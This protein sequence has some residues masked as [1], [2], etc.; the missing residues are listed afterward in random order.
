MNKACIVITTINP[1]NENIQYYSTLNGWDLIIVSDLKTNDKLYATTKCIYL[2]IK[3]QEYYFPE[4]YSKVP[5][6]SYTRKMFGYLYAIQHKYT[7]IYDTDDDNMYLKDLNSFNNLK[8]IKLVK[9]DGYLNIYKLFTDIN[10]WPRGIPPGNLYINEMPRISENT[11]ELRYAIIQG[12]VDNDPDVDAFYRI[13]INN[14]PVF[15][16]KD[17]KY[18]YILD[19][20]SV[21]PFNTQNT[22]WLDPSTFY[23]MYLPTTVSF[24]YTDILRGYIAL[25]QL[26]KINKSIVFTS[27]TAIQERNPHDLNKDYADE[28]TMY[29]TVDEV[30]HL[31]NNNKEATLRDIYII[32][33]DHGIVE[34]NELPVLDIWLK[35]IDAF[36][37]T[38]NCK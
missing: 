29:N 35:I 33:I 11:D 20:Y 3:E 23:L 18:D 9:S 6:N 16:N 25:F 8:P 27:S 38:A 10:I 19:K 7:T 4:F 36:G 12:L 34:K 28:Q 17:S 30:I 5:F 2:G 31:L 26:W 21:C 14:T 24:R 32:L 1:Q 13:N 37:Q 15:F 22:F